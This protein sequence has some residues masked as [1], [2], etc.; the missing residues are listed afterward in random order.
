MGGKTHLIQARR[1]DLCFSLHSP[2]IHGGRQ[3]KLDSVEIDV[4]KYSQ[5]WHN[6]PTCQ[7]RSYTMGANHGRQPPSPRPQLLWANIGEMRDYRPIPNRRDV[8]ILNGG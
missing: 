5:T 4:G 7:P 2:F 8:Q 1:K 3:N 6:R